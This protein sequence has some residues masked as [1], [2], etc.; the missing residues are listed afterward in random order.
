MRTLVLNAGYEPLS[1]VSYRRAILLVGTG[2]SA[3]RIIN[4]IENNKG[5][6]LN[7]VGV[8]RCVPAGTRS[9][10]I[11][12]HDPDVPS[13]GDDV[14]QEGRVVPATLPRVDFFHWVLVDLPP[15]E[16]KHIPEVCY[17][18]E[19]ALQSLDADRGFLKAGG[20]FVPL[21][22]ER[23]E[24]GMPAFGTC[25]G[26]ILLSAHILDGRED[27]WPDQLV[28]PEFSVGGSGEAKTMDAR[29]STKSGKSVWLLSAPAERTW[30]AYQP[31]AEETLPMS[32]QSPAATITTSASI[33]GWPAAE[34]TTYPEPRRRT[35][36][37]GQPPRRTTPP[38]PPTPGLGDDEK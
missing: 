28:S 27:P 16:A 18:L 9:F 12:C 14:N 23:L 31:H 22:A 5:W 10:A 36:A 17:S 25:A 34:L 3:L 33:G 26:L 2:S 8:V 30:V 19:Q 20:V 13:Q 29:L 6:G 24:A 1:V 21:D 15:E 37:T 7:V 11:I 32:F 38:T 4:L 35:A